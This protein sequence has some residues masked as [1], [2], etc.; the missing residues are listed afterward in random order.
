MAVFNKRDNQ[1]ISSSET[2]ILAHGATIKG[3]LEFETRLHVDGEIQGEIASKDFVIVGKSGKIYGDIQA[4][5]LIVNGFVEG[6]A[7]CE[8]VELLKGSVFDGKI[9]TK[10]L[11]VEA[12]AIFNGES[13]IIQEKEE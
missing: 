6:N 7:K 13:T 4:K 5:K 11:M 8:S 1:S 2:T 10:E 9:S 3:T 12:K